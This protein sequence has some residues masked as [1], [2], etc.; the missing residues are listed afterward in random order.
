MFLISGIESFLNDKSEPQK[1]LPTL[2][3]LDSQID[4][5]E[6]EIN[7]SCLNKKR[8]RQLEDIFNTHS[9]KFLARHQNGLKINQK[10]DINHICVWFEKVGIINCTDGYG[11][12]DLIKDVEWCLNKMQIISNE[13]FDS[14]SRIVIR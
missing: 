4:S 7:L 5:N 8:I 13:R 11:T 12:S 9:T 10:L 3:K 1:K 2:N 14:F 6:F